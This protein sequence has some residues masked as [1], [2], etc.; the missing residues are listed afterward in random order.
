MQVQDTATYWALINVIL[1]SIAAIQALLFV[2]RYAYL[3]RRHEAGARNARLAA[4]M[5]VVS[6]IALAGTF[7]LTEDMT[8]AMRLTD[9]MTITMLLIVGASGILGFAGEARFAN[10][11]IASDTVTDSVTT[12]VH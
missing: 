3:R 11:G 2:I 1:I 6:V 12:Q 8:A 5:G 9:D 10:S 7:Y 4:I